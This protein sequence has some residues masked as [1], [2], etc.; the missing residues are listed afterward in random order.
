MTISMSDSLSSIGSSDA[1]Q[2]AQLTLD[3]T[4]DQETIAQQQLDDYYNTS[5][6]TSLQQ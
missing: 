5:S 1:A 2:M 3:Q 6:I 4:I